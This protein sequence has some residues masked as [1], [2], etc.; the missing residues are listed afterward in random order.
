MKL[1]PGLM[2]ALACLLNT[3][4]KATVVLDTYLSDVTCNGLPCATPSITVLLRSGDVASVHATIHYH[5]KDDGLLLPSPGAYQ[6]DWNGQNLLFSPY[7]S[8]GIYLFSN[9]CGG[10]HCPPGPVSFLGSGIPPVV[11]GLNDHP[12]DIVG[13]VEL[14][15][16]ASLSP[17]EVPETVTVFADYAPVIFSAPVPEPVTYGLLIGG[18]A[19]I[20]W[21]QTLRR[22][23]QTDPL[24]TR[25]TRG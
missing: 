2:A 11:L 17:N 25:G 21:K 13:S 10:A 23:G 16:Q 18:L 3:P 7:E 24:Q 14:F 20:G 5:Y 22:S 6:M 1:L 15:S 19:F 4:A 9:M 8:G 12:D